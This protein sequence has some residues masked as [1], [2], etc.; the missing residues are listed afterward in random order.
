MAFGSNIV[1]STPPE[2][3]LDAPDVVYLPGH[4]SQDTLLLPALLS[5]LDLRPD[6]LVIAGK[7][8]LTKRLHDFRADPGKS[9]HYSG[10][11]HQELPWTPTLAIIRENIQKHLGIELNA[12]LCNYYEDGSVGMGW[13]ADKEHELGHAPNIASVSFGATRLFRFRRRS[14]WR[15]P[16]SYQTWDYQ[17]GDGDLLL[18]RGST[19]RYFEHELAARAKVSEPRLNLTFRMVLGQRPLKPDNL[20]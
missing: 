11:T 7:T 3:P 4:F 10:A 18:M 16:K 9:Y 12:C 19:Q 17:L 6:E 13:H 8:V 5:E 1:A 14:P 2:A 15:E 20:N